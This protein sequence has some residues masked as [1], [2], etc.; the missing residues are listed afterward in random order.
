MGWLTRAGRVC[1][2]LQIASV[3]CFV[4][5]ALQT[6]QNFPTA[7]AMQNLYVAIVLIVVVCLTCYL[8]YVQE[9]QSAKAMDAFKVRETPF[10][11]RCSVLRAGRAGHHA[12]VVVSMLKPL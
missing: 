5:Y 11:P 10:A 8:S 6:A 9:G 2:L 1:V 7:V 4:L 12:R 3:L